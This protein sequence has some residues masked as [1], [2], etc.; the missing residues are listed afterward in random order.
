MKRHIFLLVVFL[1]G[2]APLFAQE[3]GTLAGLITDPSGAGV[4]NANVVLTST[5]TGQ[6]RTVQSNERGEYSVPGLPAGPYTLRVEATGFQRLERSG[7]TVSSASTV[8]VDLPLT[9]G[10]TSE[11]ITVTEAASLLQSQSG[12]V[13]SLVDSKQM[14]ALPLSTR[15]F[16]DLVLLTPGAHVGSASNLSEGGSVY[17]LRGGANYSVNG[18][19]AAANGYLIDGIYDRN[20][21]L[22]TLVLVPIVD[23]IQEYRVL[24]SSYTA[25]YGEAAGAITTVTTRSG[26]NGFHGRVWEFLRNDVMNANT[27]FANQAN[28]K[29]APYR[30]NVFGGMLGGPIFR[31][32]TF[33]FAD[34]Q[35]IRQ[36]IGNTVTSTIPTLAQ[37]QMVATG[38]FAGLG[39]QIY[40]PFSTTRVGGV[41]TRAAFPGNQ[42][43][44]TLLNG[45]SAKLFS[46]LPAPTNANATNNYTISPVTTQQTNQFDVRIDQNLSKADR[47]FFKYSYDRTNQVAPGSVLTVANPPFTIGP[48]VASTTANAAASFEAFAHSG[49]LSYTKVIGAQTLIQGRAAIIRWN[50]EAIPTGASFASATAIGIPGINYNQNSGG[51]P[52]FTISGISS[53]GDSTSWPEIAH[54]TTFQYDG[55]ITRTAG[56]HTIKAGMLFLR[57]RFNGF[58]AFPT[59]GTYDFNGQFTRQIGATTTTTALADY[60]LGA[61]DAATRNIL[62]GNFGMRSFQLAPYIQDTWRVTDRL[63]L[64]YGARYEISAPPYEVNNHWANLNI[65]TGLLMVAGLNGNSRRLRNIDYNTFAPRAGLSYSIGASRKTVLRAGFGASYVDTLVGGAQ[66]YKNLPYYFSQVVA[67]SSAVPPVTLL[68]DGFPTPVA[69]DPNNIAAISVGSPT[70]WDIN[71]RQTGVF[72]YSAGVQRELR[73][74]LIAEV[75]Y[76]GT[77]TQHLLINSLNLN[78]AVPGPTAVATRRPYNTINP[79]LVNVAYRTAAA[80]SNY[81]SLQ[82]HVEKRMSSGFNF[83]LSYTYSKYLS[84]FGNPNGSGNNDIQDAR[85][86]RCNYGRM[87]DD[88]THTLVFNHVYE[89][90]FGKGRKYLNSGVTSTVLGGW[91]FSG[92]WSLHSGSPFTVFYGTN[93]SNS[94]GGGTQ[95]PNRIASGKLSSGRSITKWFDTSAFVAP[96][97]Y[98]FG[99][100]GTGILEG[101]GY[102]NVDLT[103]EKRFHITERYAFTLRGESF[104]TFNRANFNNPN[105]TIGTAQ[106]GVINSTQSPRVLQLAAKIDF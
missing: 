20:Q 80:D 56:S 69:P 87:A 72:Q 10:A 95:R 78:Q 94:S 14:V 47:L 15:N 19:L 46:L 93:V 66:M 9:I 77:R 8:S 34:Y 52:A 1:L 73:N 62:V 103:L 11:T 16:T 86:L 29:R 61:T 37:R 106:A 67:T 35:G 39:T 100:S 17:S 97:V 71:T 64:E 26:S 25:E 43:P 28:V 74:D 24:T 99:N 48:Y 51:L 59:R 13:S 21:W 12:T 55:D 40:N 76:V 84:T 38:N 102:F 6:Q 33:F 54:V 42:I 5:A 31:D 57:H 27:Y 82:V 53:L 91:D 18:S 68:S 3:S 2:A 23:S 98:T 96:A 58:S 63:T 65:Q 79:N 75:N 90:P 83:G 104:N 32:K 22:N 60:A 7:V 41:T 88:L 101:P 30:R 89:L 85:C 49:T 50:S 44:T 81:N 105:A 36:S 4:V 45:P 70:A 92:V